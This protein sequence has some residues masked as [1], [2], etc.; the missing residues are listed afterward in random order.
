MTFF[1]LKQR[2]MRETHTSRERPE[3]ASPQAFLDSLNVCR[4][5]HADVTICIP[6]RVQH[7]LVH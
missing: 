4:G 3:Q 5:Q 6:I 1:R 2:L 7:N